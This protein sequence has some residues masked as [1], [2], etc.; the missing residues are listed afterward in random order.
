MTGLQGHALVLALTGLLASACG[1][2]TSAAPSMSVT[3]PFHARVGSQPFA[4]GQT[5]TGLGTTGTTYEPRDLRLYVHDVRLVSTDG[6]EVPLAL[7]DDGAWQLEGLALLDFEDKTGLC[8]NGTPQMNTQLVGTLPPGHYSG[9]RFKVGVPF[10]LNHQDASVARSPL[11]VTTLFWGWEGGYKFLRLEGR[12][13]G[14]S[15]H[16]V[17]LGSTECQTSGINQ[18]TSCQHPNIID[19]EIPGYDPE[20]SSSAVVLDVA[21]LFAGS[22]LDTNQDNT[23]PGCMSDQADSDCV[24]I[25]QR[26]GLGIGTVAAD[27]AHQTF[28]RK[29]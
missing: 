29:E 22:N 21:A 26:L 14:L 27:P 16:V 15:G 28:F 3:I 11:N 10:E 17:H 25:F 9:L 2:G 4:C 7:T 19:V 12:T 13:A 23:A 6:T 1:G 5:Y 24:P 20:Q 8:S 18:V